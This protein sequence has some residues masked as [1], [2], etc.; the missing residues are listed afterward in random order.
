MEGATPVYRGG[1]LCTRLV[2][3]CV[4]ILSVY[5]VV[6]E[7]T[8]CPPVMKHRSVHILKGTNWVCSSEYH[9]SYCELH[10]H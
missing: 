5:Y 2:G 1:G 8:C 6:Y 7:E 3:E 9:T 10:G 4:K